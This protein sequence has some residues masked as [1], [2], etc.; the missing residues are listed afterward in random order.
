VEKSAFEMII[1]FVFL[2]KWPEGIEK[3]FCQFY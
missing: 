3:F 2:T 1:N